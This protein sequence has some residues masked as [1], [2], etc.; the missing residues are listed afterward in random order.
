MV[1]TYNI[2]VRI[3]SARK[4]KSQNTLSLKR[5]IEVGQPVKGA[6]KTHRGRRRKS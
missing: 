4:T 3:E 2:A 5:E 6:R 1:R